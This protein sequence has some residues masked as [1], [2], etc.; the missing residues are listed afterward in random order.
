LPRIRL[1]RRARLR[2]RID[3]RFTWTWPRRANRK[4]GSA[5]LTDRHNLHTPLPSRSNAARTSVRK[6]SDSAQAVTD[7]LALAVSSYVNARAGTVS[8][9]VFDLRTDQI[10][11]VGTGAPQYEAS[12]VKVAMLKTALFLSN[13]VGLAAYDQTLAQSM[14][15]YSD[16]D[17]ATALWD[18]VGGAEIIAV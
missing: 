4:W 11:N 12:V 7:P 14:I 10:W 17:S 2:D 5:R 16:N 15:E 8:A 18:S 13:G 1:S 9:A 3:F 6:S